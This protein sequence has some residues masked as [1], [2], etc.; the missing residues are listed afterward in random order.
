[1]G[2]RLAI[3]MALSWLGTACSGQSPQCSSSACAC[4]SASDCLKGQLCLAG[5]C[6]AAQS[7][8]T[9]SDCT[10]FGQTCDNGY[11]LPGTGDGGSVSD[12]GRTDAGP[13]DGGSPDGGRDG[14]LDAGPDAGPDA[15]VDAGPDAGTDAGPDGGPDAGADGGPDAGFDAGPTCTGPGCCTSDQQ[16]N[17]PALVCTGGACVSGCVPG[18]CPPAERCDDSVTGRCQ[19]ASGNGRIGAA[20]QSFADC[21]TTNTDSV[22]GFCLPFL[23]ADGGS[24]SFC[25]SLCESTSISANGC[26]PGFACDSFGGGSACVPAV[27]LGVSLGA[28]GIGTTCT[29]GAATC[30]S[31]VGCGHYGASG[32]NECSDSCYGPS[33]SDSS[34]D[35]CPSGWGCDTQLYFTPGG[36][37]A[38]GALIACTSNAVCTQHSSDAL[39]FEAAKG[40]DGF[41]HYVYREDACQDFAAGPSTA[42]TGTACAQDG[43]CAHG[44]CLT[45]K[46]AD[47]CCHSG[48]CPGGYACQSVV[49][50]LDS[51][52]MA[53]VP[54][55]GSGALG[56]PCAPGGSGACRAQVS[57][58]VSPSQDLCIPS[59]PYASGGTTG[60]CSDTCCNDAECGDGGYYCGLWPVLTDGK[61]NPLFSS[62]CLKL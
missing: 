5:F 34:T 13:G 12:G 54:T 55:A 45:G 56:A 20:C 21:G 8:Q 40:G 57:P 61:G 26:P 62:L 51:V 59:N 1:M 29:L 58:Q 15:G 2:R 14:G 42:T 7:C 37:D 50:Q 28:G 10:G 32:A 39:C 23:L 38:G 47:P 48:D 24:S 60:Y 27:D 46:C 19:P 33:P 49:Q 25:S 43:D 35:V 9:T 6:A 41:C 53:C 52:V 4:Q 3:G 30:D 16:C 18:G 22:S 17:P 31:P 11:C 44:F 36:P